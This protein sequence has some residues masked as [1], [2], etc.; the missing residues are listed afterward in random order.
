MPFDEE[1]DRIVAENFLAPAETLLNA[2]VFS[3][4]LDTA[5]LQTKAAEWNAPPAAPAPAPPQPQPVPAPAPVAGEAEE[6]VEEPAPVPDAVAEMVSPDP[7]PPAVPRSAF[8]PDLT[9]SPM[10]DD[11]LNRLPQKDFDSVLTFAQSRSLDC[12]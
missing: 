1:L 5:S 3:E 10:Q 12:H 4:A 7:V 8:F 6:W 11:I 9:L 2:P